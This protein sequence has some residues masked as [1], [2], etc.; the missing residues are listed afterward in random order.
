MRGA[1]AGG[2]ISNW[3]VAALGFVAGVC[4]MALMI[5]LCSTFCGRENRL[6]QSK[7]S[8]SEEGSSPSSGKTPKKWINLNLSLSS[9]RLLSMKKTKSIASTEGELTAYDVNFVKEEGGGV[10]SPV[11]QRS[12]LMGERCEPP[13]FSGHIFYDEFGNRVDDFPFK[14][15][16]RAAQIP[17]SLVHNY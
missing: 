8:M 9:K 1:G 13:S 5:C 15:P 17:S 4:A 11:W 12:I 6:I 16:S 7:E 2:R 3:L 14:S 10:E